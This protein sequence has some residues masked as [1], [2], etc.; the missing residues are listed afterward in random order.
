MS[1]PALLPILTSDPDLERDAEALYD[2]VSELVRVYQSL[3]RDRICCH[4]ISITQCNAL[5]VLARRGGLTLGELAA[6]LYLD[7]STA[8]RVVDA[9]QRKG[10]VDRTT[11]PDDGRA[12]LLVT[13]PRGKQL[14]QSIR[15]G[16]LADEQRLLAG[17]DPEIRRVLPQLIARL[18]RAVAGRLGNGETCCTVD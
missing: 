14:Y 18:A 9:L 6:H 16:L 2:S 11:H 1:S 10:Y 3:D 4:D 8:S 17:F 15:K 7:K 12:V 5:E 13:T